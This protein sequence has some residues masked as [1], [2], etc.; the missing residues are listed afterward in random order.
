ME[1]CHITIQEIVLEMGVSTGSVHSILSDDLCMQRVLAKFILKLLV[2][3]KELCIEIAWDKLDCT[4]R[5]PDFRKIIITDDEAW[6]HGYGSETKFQSS[7]WKH[8]TSP[9][10]PKSKTSLQQCEGNADLF[11]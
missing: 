1:D 3:E 5:D 8:T 7:Q 10:V 11:L 6:V 9:K 4:N 2:E